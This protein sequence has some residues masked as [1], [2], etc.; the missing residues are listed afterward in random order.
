MRILR[1]GSMGDEVALLQHRLLR[2]GFDLAVTHVFDEATETA[3]KK[4]QADAGL[5]VDGLAGP[6][7]MLALATGKRDAKHL[8]DAD[9]VKAAASLDVP[10]EC[11]RAVNEV[12][13]RGEGF[14]A[15]GRPVI[16]FERHVFWERLVTHG[17]DPKPLAARYPNIVSETRGGYE[18]GSAEYVRLA[19]AQML[20][21]VAAW[22]A[23]SWGA[24]QVMGEHWKRLGYQSPQEFV[25]RM[26][27]SEREQLDAFV[28]FVA[29]DAK[30][31]AALKSRRWEAF[32]EGYNGKAYKANLYDVK[33][34]R[35][36]ERYAPT[37]TLAP[38]PTPAEAT[39]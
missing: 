30:L 36:Y 22:E 26:E 25:S 1:F 19:W 39:A 17:I 28:R 31:L 5:V 27:A 35:A 24:F 13:S 6:K 14:L 4:V 34:A 15:D 23:T 38:K 9:I 18:G 33:L 11:V 8:A 12:E 21:P 3:I 10:V 2:A 20:A 29:A 16:L 37:P 7:T 32:A